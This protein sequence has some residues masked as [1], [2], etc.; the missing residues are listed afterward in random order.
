M[1]IID[2]DP[3]EENIYLKYYFVI[4]FMITQLLILNI[5][6]GFIIDVI[7][8][9]LEEKYSSLVNVSEDVFAV[10]NLDEGKEKERDSDSSDSGDSEKEDEED[11]K[12]GG[13]G[14]LSKGN[15][16]FSKIGQE[17]GTGFEGI[18]KL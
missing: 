14:K 10:L 5:I 17:L 2:E 16:F 9:H 8:T 4:F 1:G 13:L 18:K 6:V 3:N 7:L 12:D 11:K 15:N